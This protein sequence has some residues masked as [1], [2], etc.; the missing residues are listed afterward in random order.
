M[1]LGTWESGLL[2]FFDHWDLIA[3][4]FV[5]RGQLDFDNI[6]AAPYLSRDYQCLSPDERFAEQRKVVN[7]KAKSFKSLGAAL[8]I[9]TLA[10]LSA[11]AGSGSIKVTHSDIPYRDKY[12]TAHT[13]IAQVRPSVSQPSSNEVQVAV[14]VKTPLE[15]GPRRSVFIHR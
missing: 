4:V 8:V 7:M 14:M 15:P 13:H 12:E 1:W 6:C 9:G 2:L 10:A 11:V 3:S 5:A